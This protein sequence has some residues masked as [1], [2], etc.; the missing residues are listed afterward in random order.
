M[1][2]WLAGFGETISN[3]AP[4]ELGLSLAII[5]RIIRSVL[6]NHLFLIRPVLVP[7]RFHWLEVVSMLIESKCAIKTFFWQTDRWTKPTYRRSFS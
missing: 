1:A 5:K 2:G 6:M 3:S 4:T 7:I